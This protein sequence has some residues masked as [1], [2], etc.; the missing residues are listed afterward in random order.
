[1]VTEFYPAEKAREEFL[2]MTGEQLKLK[3]M[4]KSA[5]KHKNE[6]AAVQQLA[7]FM[8]RTQEYR[9]GGL[10]IEDVRRAVHLAGNEWELGNAAGSVFKGKEWE[11]AGWVKAKHPDAHGRMVRL[12]RLKQH[13]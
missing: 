6:L 11:M 3:G 1:M 2:A 7:R 4:S 12:W 13:S 10:S 5:E 8:A 9:F